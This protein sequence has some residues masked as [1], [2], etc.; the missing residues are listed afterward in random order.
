MAYSYEQPE[1]HSDYI[2]VSSPR[3]FIQDYVAGNLYSGQSIL[4]VSSPLTGWTDVGLISN[5]AVPVTRNIVKLQ[6]GLPK[7]TRKSFELSREAQVTLTFHEM[8]VGTIQQL[9]GCSQK[10]VISGAPVVSQT[11]TTNG[12]STLGTAEETN[13]FVV[14]D[15]VTFWDISGDALVGDEVISVVSPS[16]KEVTITGEWATAPVETDVLLAKCGTVAS[17][18]ASP[19]AITLGAGEADRFVA[20]DRVVFVKAGDTCLTD[21]KATTDRVYVTSVDSG[22]AILNLSAAFIGT[23]VATD[24]LVAYKSIELLDPLGSI[25]EKSLLVFFDSVVNDIQRQVAIW[26]PKVTV[27]GSWAPDFKGGE[28]YMDASLTFEVQSTTQIVTDGTSKL[29]LQLPFLFD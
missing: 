21:M 7:T 19:P 6:L 3:I 25:A 12:V 14:G 27:S 4:A 15:A 13:R 1:K 5:V 18:A 8:H 23:P 29:V 9:T 17:Y 22:G 24:L 20:G 10:N 11:N 2:I 28:N 26:Y 16:T